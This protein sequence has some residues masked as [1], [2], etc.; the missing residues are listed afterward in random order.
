MFRVLFALS[1]P[2][3]SFLICTLPCMDDLLLMPFL[4]ELWRQC[5]QIRIEQRGVLRYLLLLP[6][7]TPLLYLSSPSLG[8][9]L[10]PRLASPS[11]DPLLEHNSSSDPRQRA[12]Q[13]PFCISTRRVVPSR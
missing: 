8:P 3:L 6:P 4:L 10:G 13:G 5:Q 1:Y 9:S 2:I 12:L 11:Q 7:L